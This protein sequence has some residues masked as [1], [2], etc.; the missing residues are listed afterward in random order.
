MIFWLDSGNFLGHIIWCLLSI[1]LPDWGPRFA[2]FFENLAIKLLTFTVSHFADKFSN[3]QRISEHKLTTGSGR[4]VPDKYCTIRPRLALL[5]GSRSSWARTVFFNVVHCSSRSRSFLTFQPDFC[6]FF[7]N[8]RRNH[9]RNFVVFLNTF[10]VR[11]IIFWIY[12]QIFRGFRFRSD[13][14]VRGRILRWNFG[15]VGILEK[16]RIKI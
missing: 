14:F 9:H 4:K 7:F 16:R 1:H 10:Y 12:F 8:T 6:T 3:E 13:F 5:G 11:G 2:A 15:G